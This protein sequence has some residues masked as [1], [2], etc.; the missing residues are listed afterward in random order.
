[1]IEYHIISG[2]TLEDFTLTVQEA[3]ESPNDWVLQGG[4]SVVA[5]SHTSQSEPFRFFQAVS[6]EVVRRS[7]V[8]EGPIL[9]YND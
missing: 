5:P 3:L 9:T 7:H 6:R 2:R 1:M 4:V 8:E